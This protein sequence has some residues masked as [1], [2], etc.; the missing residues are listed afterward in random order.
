MFIHRAWRG[1]VSIL[2]AIVVVN[3]FGLMTTL[4]MGSLLGLG[5]IYLTELIQVDISLSNINRSIMI[6]LLSIYGIFTIKCTWLSAKKT[7]KKI[8]H[9]LTRVWALLTA[10]CLASAIYYLFTSITQ[11]Q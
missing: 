10:M 4:F 5:L 7:H 1:E 6:F 2:Q 8:S 3:I 9:K 11:V